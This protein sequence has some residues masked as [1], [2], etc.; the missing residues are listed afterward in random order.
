MPLFVIA[1]AIANCNAEMDIYKFIDTYV[2]ACI[3]ADVRFR[4]L[5][6][7]PRN[8]R[9]YRPNATPNSPAN[10]ESSEAGRLTIQSGNI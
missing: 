2:Y 4:F 10:Y 6:C 7:Q 5:D 8:A 9:N 1:R 3:R